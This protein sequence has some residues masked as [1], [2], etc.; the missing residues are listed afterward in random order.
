MA[1]MAPCPGPKSKCLALATSSATSDAGSVLFAVRVGNQNYHKYDSCIVVLMHIH[2]LSESNTWVGRMHSP[3]P[4]MST[5]YP[6]WDRVLIQ[7]SN[8]VPPFSGLWS[9]VLF[10]RNM[11]IFKGGR[12]SSGTTKSRQHLLLH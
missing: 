7:Y 6:S 10:Y 1:K 3:L 2:H 12:M 9:P 8:P 5:Q 4:G 11:I